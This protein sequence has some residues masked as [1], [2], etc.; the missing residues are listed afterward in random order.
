M[1]LRGM[2]GRQTVRKSAYKLAL[3]PVRKT[4]IDIEEEILKRN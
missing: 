4:E 3:K 2:R 1:P